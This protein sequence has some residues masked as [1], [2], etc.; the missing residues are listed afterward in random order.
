M[1][2]HAILENATKNLS[3]LHNDLTR[4][5]PIKQKLS[6][7]DKQL[8][9]LQKESAAV[10]KK[11]RAALE[12]A[13]VKNGHRKWRSVYQAIRSV[14]SEQEISKLATQLDDIR[15]QVDT[16]LLVSLRY[17]LSDIVFYICH[18]KLLFKTG[19]RSSIS[20]PNGATKNEPDISR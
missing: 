11:L 3:E 18:A 7:A 1:S 15:K 13:K 17:A 4:E 8:V 5:A 12:K 10:A 14:Y 2:Y 9:A 19:G 20:I 6:V 16:V